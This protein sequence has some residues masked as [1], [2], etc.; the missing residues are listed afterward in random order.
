MKYIL[1]I[2][3]LAVILVCTYILYLS[4]KEPLEFKQEKETRT[5][6]VVQSLKTIKDCQEMHRDIYGKFASSFERC[7]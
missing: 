1:N 4:I 6:A 3:I 5:E 7:V 2:L